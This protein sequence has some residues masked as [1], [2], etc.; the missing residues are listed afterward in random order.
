ML[1]SSLMK[2]PLMKSLLMASYSTIICLLIQPQIVFSQ[3][4][5]GQAIVRKS[6][7]DTDAAKRL[8]TIVDSIVRDLRQVFQLGMDFALNL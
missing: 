4:T 7:T 3:N 2:L 1:S 5:T 8:P 6:S